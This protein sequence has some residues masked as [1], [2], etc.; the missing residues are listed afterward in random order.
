MKS[1]I[2]RGAVLLASLVRQ[3]RLSI[4]RRKMVE[5]ERTRV[6]VIT[7]GNSGIGL[8]IAEGF[9]RQNA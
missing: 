3:L 7:G 8:G 5:T 2:S 9:A 4:L 1:A 6:V